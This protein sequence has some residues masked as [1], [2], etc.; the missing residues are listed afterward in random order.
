[1]IDAHVHL[2]PGIGG[3]CGS[4]F[5]RSAGY[6]RLV[7]GNGEVFQ[8][9]PC[10]F[11]DG[12]STTEMYLRHMEVH[13]IDR[14]VI[15]QGPFYGEQNVYAAEAVR[16]WP[17][18]FTASGMIDPFADGA[19]GQLR[20]LGEELGCRILKLECSSTFG[21]SSFHRP[22]SYLD[23]RFLAAMEG[24]DRYGMTVVIDTGT[25]VTEAYR[26][27]ELHVLATRYPQLQFVIP[28]LG[29]P[30]G[31][32][33]TEAQNTAWEAMFALG[34][35]PN[36]V[37]DISSLVDIE[38]EDY[39]YPMARACVKK[40]FERY[41]AKKMIFGTD[42][43]GVLSHCTYRQAIS[44]LYDYCE[45]LTPAEKDLIFDKNARLVYKI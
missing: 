26:P 4:G 7:A 22:F 45:F 35:L 3:Y 17:D 12:S 15:M 41:G 2:F 29:F 19:D 1:M 8:T 14:A 36:V 25:P 11:V 33:A 42:Y 27:E 23:D 16:Q 30:P 10:S 18:R 43:P 24:A 32:G 20:Y 38:G 40:A 6:G 21:L 9:M 31:K 44:F 37:F 34:E 5:I 39:P 13:G 28:H